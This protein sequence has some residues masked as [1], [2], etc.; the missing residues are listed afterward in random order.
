[1]GSPWAGSRIRIRTTTRQG[2]DLASAGNFFFLLPPSKEAKNPLALLGRER[3]KEGLPMKTIGTM[4][5]LAS[6]LL[7]A[8]C[9]A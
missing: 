9:T 3:P 8:A 5:C 7:L 2:P 4:L 6:L 1:M